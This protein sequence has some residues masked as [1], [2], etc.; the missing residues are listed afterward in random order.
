MP[1]KTTPNTIPQ[2][3]RIEPVKDDTVAFDCLTCKERYRFDAAAF[4][5]NPTQQ[6]EELTKTNQTV[7]RIFGQKFLAFVVA[8]VVYYFA[9]KWIYGPNVPLGHGIL[10]P[11]FFAVVAF[12]IAMPLFSAGLFG[13]KRM[14]VY[15]YKCRQCQSDVLI[16]SNGKLLAL[17]VRPPASKGSPEKK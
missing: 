5:N 1:E 12:S 11:V 17:P 9:H 8:L 7:G 3:W 10:I 4:A 14:P 2:Q 15:R 13:G 6:I 16:A